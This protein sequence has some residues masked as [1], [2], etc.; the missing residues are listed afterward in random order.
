MADQLEVTVHSTNQKLGYTASLRD[1][2][3]IAMDYIPPFGDYQGYLPLELLLMSLSS[4]AGGTIG[5]LL[6]KMGKTVTAIKVN[7]KGTRREQHPTCFKTIQL[8]FTVNSS[9]AKDGDLQKAIKLRLPGMG[10][11]E[12]QC[13]GFDG[14]PD[15]CR[16]NQ[17]GNDAKQR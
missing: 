16:V 4:C 8:E 11:A 3:P 14:V 6:R 17:G 12:G 7:A 13:R 15:R 2:P 1:L 10:N 9:D 5:L